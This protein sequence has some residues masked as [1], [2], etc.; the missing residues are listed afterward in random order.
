MEQAN[1]HELNRNSFDPKNWKDCGN[2]YLNLSPQHSEEWFEQRKYRLTA[3]NFG[4]AINESNFSGVMELAMDISQLKPK[5]FDKY[6]TFIM[7]HGTKYEDAARDY[8]AKLHNV[9]VIEM[10]L[11]VWKQDPRLGASLDGDV[12]GTDGIIEIKCPLKMYPS[13]LEHMEKLKTGWKPPPFYREHIF[14][15]RYA[16]MQGQMIII[17]NKKWC[18]YVVYATESNLCFIDRVYLDIDYWNNFLYP[19]LQHFLNHFLDPLIKDG[20]NSDLFKN[21]NEL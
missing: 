15:S 7:D 11:A 16:Q 12:V 17:G 13:I 9:T 14:A 3:S 6:T 20:F 8:Y 18:D 5:K 19:K 1:I 2:F 10:G 21:V 4:A